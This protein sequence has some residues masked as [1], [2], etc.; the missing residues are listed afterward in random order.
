MS[1]ET[2]TN[3]IFTDALGI[4]WHPCLSAMAIIKICRTGNMTIDSLMSQ[5]INVGDLIEAVWFACEDEAQG[6]NVSKE[7]FLGKRLG[8]EQIGPAIQTLWA[9]VQAAFPSVTQMGGGKAKGKAPF[10]HGN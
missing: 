8:V 7:E 4:E 6:R 5:K 1:E 3:K 10:V 2:K 9:S